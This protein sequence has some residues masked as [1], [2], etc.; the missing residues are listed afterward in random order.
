MKRIPVFV[1]AG[2]LALAVL[3]SCS[4]DKSS[5]TEPPWNPSID[6]ADFVPQIDNPF[7]PFTPGTVFTYTGVTDGHP[8]IN[9]VHVTR[10]TK[11]ILGVTCTV[12]QDTVLVDGRLEEATLDW[13]A[14]DTEGNV[15]YF[16]EDS[17]E[18]DEAGHVISTE[19]SWEGGVG[20]AAPGIVMKAQPQ[21][22]ESYHQEYLKEVAEDMAQVL[23]LDETVT[24]PYGSYTDCLKTKEWTPLEEEVVENKYYVRGIGM[25]RAVMV[26]GGSDHSELAGVSTE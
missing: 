4:E 16:G 14:Q 11:V 17:K 9:R 3:V 13:Y 20:G 15:W 5:P 22:G 6:P 19:G 24:V 1:A 12:V 23:A 7:L 26:Q 2:A 21:I 10:Q 25:L 18:F 8:E